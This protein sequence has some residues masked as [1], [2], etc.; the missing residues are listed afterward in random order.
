MRS[1]SCQGIAFKEER[2][3]SYLAK[4]PIPAFN[5]IEYIEVEQS[6]Y[7]DCRWE[8]Q[9]YFLT[10]DNKSATDAE[11]ILSYYYKAK[12]WASSSDDAMHIALSA[13]S[14]FTDDIKVLNAC[15]ECVTDCNNA[16]FC[17]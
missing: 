5:G 3:N 17:L 10:S 1:L 13:F 15:I 7:D 8:W 6:R 14:A 2:L 4:R 9:C 12:G 11:K 16:G